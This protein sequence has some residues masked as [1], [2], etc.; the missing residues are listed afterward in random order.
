VSLMIICA[1]VTDV[2]C[3]VFV[4]LH[5]VHSQHVIHRDIKPQNLLLDD[6]GFLKV[7]FEWHVFFKLMLIFV[8]EEYYR[9]SILVNNIMSLLDCRF[10]GV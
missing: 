10:W 6:G 7:R 5:A 4:L 9:V 3:A 2:K 8:R 1:S